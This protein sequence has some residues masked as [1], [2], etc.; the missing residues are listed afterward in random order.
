MALVFPEE[1]TLR[2]PPGQ[3]VKYVPNNRSFGAFMK[4]EQIRGPVADVAAEIAALATATVPPP[5]A[6]TDPDR[7]AASYEVEREAGL[8]LIGGN[9]RVMVRVEGTGDG[10]ERAEF[11]S[12]GGKRYRTLANAGS[13]LGDW[14]PID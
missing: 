6:N 14:K 10:V 13:R 1:G 3:R 2:M 8:L 4:S 7:A 11:G 9:L 5:S 12:R